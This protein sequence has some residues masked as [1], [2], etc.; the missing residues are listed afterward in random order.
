MTAI[1]RMISESYQVIPPHARSGMEKA[2]DSGMNA[3]S[4][5]HYASTDTRIT[6]RIPFV[7]TAST[8]FL[9]LANGLVITSPQRVPAWLLVGASVAAIFTLYYAKRH[10]KTPM[11]LLINVMSALFLGMTGPR[12][13]MQYAFGVSDFSLWYPETFMLMGTLF[14]LAGFTVMHTIH[15]IITGQLP[16]VIQY[17]VDKFKPGPKPPQP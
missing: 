14:G 4:Y 13:F 16:A 3:I 12:P 1:R 6:E 2:W 9:I 11:Y 7:M 15:G 8:L 10:D 17:F 5:F